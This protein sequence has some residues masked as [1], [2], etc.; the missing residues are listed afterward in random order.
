MS[1]WWTYRLTSFL[2][3]SPRTYYRLIELYNESIWPAQ[4]AA[5][6]C[7]LTIAVLLAMDREHP[8]QTALGVITPVPV[9]PMTLTMSAITAVVLGGTSIF[10]GVGSV[11]GTLL[12]VAALAVLSNGLVHARQPLRTPTARAGLFA[13]GV[14]GRTL[15]GKMGFRPHRTAAGLEQ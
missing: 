4:L 3:F 13:S 2:L 15:A 9:V 5:A 14:V 7:G 11:H 10:G 8:M 6:A 1:E 12:G